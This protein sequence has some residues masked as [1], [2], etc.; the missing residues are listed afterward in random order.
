[1]MKIVNIFRNP[2]SP[3]CSGLSL[4]LL[5]IIH[6]VATQAV[7]SPQ[8]CTNEQNTL[9]SEPPQDSGRDQQVGGAAADGH[10]KYQSK[11]TGG[12]GSGHGNATPRGKIDEIQAKI[13]EVVP[14]W[15][16][17]MDGLWRGGLVNQTTI[18]LYILLFISFT[19]LLFDNQ[20]LGLSIM[21]TS[22]HYFFLLNFCQ[23]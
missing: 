10:S 15:M 20:N 11:Q 16:A 9:A 4:S 12:G 23:Q 19:F 2:C 13:A 7:N 18:S 22:L 17:G 1:M 3:S 21:C 6:L 5:I 14:S 8:E